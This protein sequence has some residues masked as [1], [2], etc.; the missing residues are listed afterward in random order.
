MAVDAGVD[1]EDA[2]EEEEHAEV[3][4]DDSDTDSD[5][6]DSDSDC[7]NESDD[8]SDHFA[9]SLFCSSRMKTRMELHR[10]C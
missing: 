6:S 3:D 1:E 7:D 2:A 10:E 4:D 9:N 8:D 5:D